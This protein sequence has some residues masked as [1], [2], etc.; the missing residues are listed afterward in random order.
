VPTLAA[1]EDPNPDVYVRID[2]DQNDSKGAADEAAAP[3]TPRKPITS[4][5]CTTIRHLRARAGRWSRFR[6]LKMYIVW[7]IASSMVMT[8]LEIPLGGATYLGRVIV[9]RVIAEVLLANLEMAWIHIVISESSPKPF[10]QR[11]PGRRSWAKIA[12]AAALRA[13]ASQIALYLP[14]ALGVS[15]RVGESAQPLCKTIGGIVATAGAGL[16]LAVLVEVPANV[17]FIRVAAS[18]LPEEDE[19]I[20]PFDRTFGGRVVPTILGGSGK[21]GLLDAWRSFNWASR[22]RFMKVLVKA[23]MIQLALGVLFGL[24]LVGEVSLFAQ[25]RVGK[26]VRMLI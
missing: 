8:L 22:A 9:T 11:I 6:G 26:A 20:V 15:L 7:Q 21:I 13:V 10:Y 12:P 3:L 18:M 5:L 24:I 2:S 17:T 1:V 19:A 25:E 23:F 16:A 4:K 14:L